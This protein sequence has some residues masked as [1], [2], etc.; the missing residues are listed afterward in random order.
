MPHP[1]FLQLEAGEAPVTCGL[2]LQYFLAGIANSLTMTVAYALFMVRF[3]S[4][5]IPF[6]YIANAIVVVLLSSAYLRLSRQVSF[7]TGLMAIYGGLLFAIILFRLALLVTDANWVIFALPILFQTMLI[8]GNL[9]FWGLAGRLFHVRQGKRL[10]G[11]VGSGYWL[12]AVVAGFVTP[13][14][15]RAFGT[16]NLLWVAVLSLGGALGVLRYLTRSYATI[17]EQPAS[18]RAV[19]TTSI[20]TDQSAPFLNRY[21][22]LIFVVISCLWSAFYCI[23]TVFLE[24][25]KARYPEPDA[26]ASFFGLFVG[27]MGVFT[28]CGTTLV[29]GRVMS[30]YG[31]RTALLLLPVSLLCL[32]GLMMLSEGGPA[33]FPE[34][35]WLVTLTRLL[36]VALIY[37]VNTPALNVVYQPLLPHQRSRTQ[38]VVEG[39]VQPLA[40]GVTG[41]GILIVLRVLQWESGVLVYG[42]CIS[43][44]VWL[45]AAVALGHA[46]LEQV[47]H[48]LQRR[49]LS[50]SAHVVTESLLGGGAP[51]FAALQAPLQAEEN[52]ALL[53]RI[54]RQVARRRDVHALQMLQSK[55]EITDEWVRHYLLL[56]LNRCGYQSEDRAAVIREITTEVKHAAYLLAAT[57]ALRES[58]AAGA[59]VASLQQCYHR[60]CVR[61]LLLLSFVYPAEIINRIHSVF[62][63]TGEGAALH[64]QRAYALETLDMYLSRQEKNLVLPLLEEATVDLRLQKLQKNCP[65]PAWD[66]ERWLQ[67]FIAGADLWSNAWVQACAIYTAG[68]LQLVTLAE[69]IRSRLTSTHLVIRTA[70]AY[71]LTQMENE[72]IERKEQTLSMLPLVER[73]LLL[74]RTSFFAEVPDYTLSEVATLLR[75]VAYAAGD[76]MIEK[77]GLD[78]SLYIVVS[79]QVRVH[80]QERTVAILGVGEVF[81]EMAILDTAPRSQSVTAI[82]PT[83][84][85]QLDQV[86][87]EELV[88][89]YSEVARGIIRV[90]VR[91]LRQDLVAQ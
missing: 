3:G 10:F 80:D 78:K 40:I 4:Q 68:K 41:V 69:G 55:F 56:A 43:V 12:A 74:K 32:I 79:G 6:I 1:R 54:I 2:I 24:H 64:T 31:V 63:V 36:D 50:T 53:L 76:T 22:V 15:V 75:E 88:E 77:G 57:V 33:F 73:I 11:L 29:A 9:V 17:I 7:A 27:C 44:L 23:D 52:Q 13:S 47:Q 18:S 26:F 20:A 42:A 84:L 85:L 60:Y 51:V 83:L 58:P 90:L 91:R 38:V 70:A 86:V 65:L 71:V 14:L 67:F 46:Y 39:I 35:F 89:E 82:E 81:G 72:R 8:L 59:L 5:S 19:H 37:A 34:M 45:I 21:S 25:A 87:F 49:H 61:V 66:S 30:R 28:L 62:A 48:V 16:V